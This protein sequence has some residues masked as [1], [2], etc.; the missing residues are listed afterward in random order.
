[1]N[2]FRYCGKM[3]KDRTG[4]NAVPIALP[5][6]AEDKLEG[7]IDLI[8]MEEWVYQGEDLGASWVRQ[9]IRA[10]PKRCKS[11]RCQEFCQAH[12]AF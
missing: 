10:S 5:I 9:P 7:I 3:I 8:T 6:G 4:A 11:M 2:G 12:G 1:M